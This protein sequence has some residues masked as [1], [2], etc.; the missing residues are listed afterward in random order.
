MTARWPLVKLGELVRQ[1]SRAQPVDAG[2]EYR[3]LGVRLDGQGP[4][5]RE[6]IPGSRT[7]AK[8]L[9]QVCAGDFIYSR[10]F[11]W[12]GAF[13]V[14]PGGLDGCFV[15]GEFP[16]FLPVADRIDVDLLRYWF[17]LP[18]TLERVGTV[19]TGSTPLT[20]NRFKERFFLELEI[21][22]PPLEEQRRIVARLEGIA[23]RIKETQAL[24]QRATDETT[25]LFQIVRS[26]E[27]TNSEYRKVTLQ[28][29][30]ES[31]VDNLHSTPR[32]DGDAF[33]CI[34]SQDIGWGTINYEQALRT[35]EEEFYLRT[36]RGEPRE[37]DIVF[38]REGDVGRCAVVD[39]SRRF[40]LGQRVMMFRPL[41]GA[42]VPRFLMFQLMS[43]PVL[44]QQI[45]TK[46]AGTT[47]HHVNIKHLRRVQVTLPSTDEQRRIVRELE[48][49]QAASSSLTRLQ[50]EA[51]HEL[52]ALMPAILDRAF[53][54]E[55]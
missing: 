20:R 45:L 16:T 6:T 44:D 1:T 21:T 10:L 34:R 26:A 11:A 28:D 30:C 33:P 22:L 29:A 4:F 19:C 31:V 36:R 50:A 8:T 32:Y 13:G 52:D 9:F 14:V 24:C 7:A 55:L 39:G 49:L 46:K 53:R 3:L 37:G 42:V 27:F 18:S 51:S 54:G 48:S 5:H 40:S 25:T 38:V 17:R 43:R 15:S 23:T 2:S 47:S 35:S 41:R 12:R